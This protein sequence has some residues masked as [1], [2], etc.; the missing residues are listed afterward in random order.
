MSQQAL[1]LVFA[2]IAVGVLHTLVPDH[3]VPITLLARTRHWTRAQTARAALG[4]GL[5]HTLSTLA[6]GVLVWV[7]GVAFAARFGNLVSVLSSVALIAFGAWIAIS[8][9]REL[10]THPGDDHRDREHH[11]AGARTSLMLILGSSPMVEGIPAFFAAAKFGP[12][13]IALMSLCFAVSTIATY[14]VLCTISRSALERLHLGPLE[15]YGEVLSG[16]VIMLVGIVFILPK[17]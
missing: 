15:R 17:T 3:W 16:A 5:G 2:V 11:S 1:L 8:S 10:R 13:L 9:W 14:V 6:I 12:G 7:A 4:A